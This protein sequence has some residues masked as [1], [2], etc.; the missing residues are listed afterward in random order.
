M[1]IVSQ[2]HLTM[3]TFDNVFHRAFYRLN[4][5]KK[6]L[7]AIHQME[8]LSIEMKT[9]GPGRT[10][11]PGLELSCFPFQSSLNS[12]PLCNPPI[13]YSQSCAQNC[14]CLRRLWA[15]SN[16]HTPAYQRNYIRHVLTKTADVHWA[17]PV[18]Q[19]LHQTVQ[20]GATTIPLFQMKE[21]SL[22]IAQGQ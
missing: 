5:L 11:V 21:L 7:G 22:E 12:P 6:T 9:L 13:L 10:W 14:T 8:S 4:A 20:R 1:F 16:A 2:I 19:V 15:E 3:K 17:L 18:S